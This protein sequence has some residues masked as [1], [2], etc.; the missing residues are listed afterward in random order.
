M[1]RVNVINVTDCE[2]T[3]I[4]RS[5]RQCF[6]CKQYYR[7]A[8]ALGVEASQGQLESHW[9]QR[10]GEMLQI[11]AVVCVVHVC[12]VLGT[13]TEVHQA[14]QVCAMASIYHST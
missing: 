12:H 6:R 3:L 9:I 2:N 4:L 10:C 13:H 8:R 7:H 5:M 14:H 11:G 1:R